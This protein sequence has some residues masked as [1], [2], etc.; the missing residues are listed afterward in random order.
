MIKHYKRCNWM[1]II[2]LILDPRHKMI[3]FDQTEWGRNLKVEAKRR[4]KQ[5]FKEKYCVQQENIN[6]IKQKVSEEEDFLNFSS[7]YSVTDKSGTDWENELR[8]Y[9]EALRAPA[10]TDILLWWEK[11]AYLYPRL[12]KIAR[13]ILCVMASSVPVERLFSSA[14]AIVSNERCSLK[15][16]SVRILLCLHSWIRSS[17]KDSISCENL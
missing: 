17:L 3:T 1:Y 7:I 9:T 16:Q 5:M 14:S 6:I 15:Y 2:S 13:D 8:E 10:D 4:F 12:S 11:H